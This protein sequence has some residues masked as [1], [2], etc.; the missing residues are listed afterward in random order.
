MGY[1]FRWY[2]SRLCNLSQKKISRFFIRYKKCAPTRNAFFLRKYIS[3]HTSPNKPDAV[4]QTSLD[5]GASLLSTLYATTTRRSLDFGTSFLST[6]YATTIIVAYSVILS[7]CFAV[8][9]FYHNLLSSRTASQWLV[10]GCAR[11]FI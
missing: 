4:C 1:D 8:A 9:W 3:Y 6:L 5:F 2:C 10:G 7:H 11:V